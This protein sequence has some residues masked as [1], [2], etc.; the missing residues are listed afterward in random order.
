MP[1]IERGGIVGLGKEDYTIY[2]EFQGMMVFKP[3][4]V[5]YL[6]ALTGALCDRFQARDGFFAVIDETG[7]FDPV[8]KTGES[9]WLELP[10]MLEKMPAYFEEHGDAFYWDGTGVII[11]LFN[12]DENLDTFLGVLGLADVSPEL[13]PNGNRSVLDDALEKARTVLWQRRYLTS[14]YQVLRSRTKQNGENGFHS[15]SVL[16]QN[17]LLDSSNTAE[18]DEVAVWVKDALT[19]YWGGPRLSENPLLNWQIVRR[20]AAESG[21]NE[22]N[23]L[24]SILKQALEELRPEGERNTGGEWMLYNLIDLKF[25]EKQKVKDIVRRLSMSEADF[26]RKQRVAVE[27]LSK[28]IIRMEHERQDQQ[29]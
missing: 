19:H 9:S 3:E 14:A 20:L 16:N 5:T 8:V 28:V 27:A 22:I 25:F 2:K 6:E 4:L 29:S 15:G 7:V 11:P 18:L 10:Q 17:A 21:E 12:H 26:Y 23:S 24:R 13:F 1:R